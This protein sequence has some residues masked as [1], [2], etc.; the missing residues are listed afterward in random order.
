MENI[1]ES[2]RKRERGERSQRSS[3]DIYN[4]IGGIGSETK[5]KITL[6]KRM[7][8]KVIHLRAWNRRE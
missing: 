1:E 7:G 4:E 5:L 3:R 2:E 6:T 8:R